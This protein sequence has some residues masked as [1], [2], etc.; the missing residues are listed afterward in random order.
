M[1]CCSNCFNNS[2]LQK[3]ISESSKSTGQCDF[4]GA[5]GI[6]VIEVREL[7]GLFDN[8]LSMYEV[9]EDYESGEPLID[10]IQWHWQIF[11]EENLGEDNMARLLEKIANSDWDDDD[12]E[13]MLRARELYVPPAGRPL[14]STHRERWEEFCSDV[15]ENPDVPLPFDEYFSG[16][17]AEFEEH[18]PFG[19]TLYRSVRGFAVGQYGER[20][21]F[22]VGAPPE[23][24]ALAGRGNVEDDR[25][26]Y[27]A[28]QEKTAIAEVRPPLGYRVSIGTLRLVREARILDLTKDVDDLNPFTTESLGW[29][30][31][32]R[33][34]LGGF[35]EEMSRPLERDDDKTHYVPCQRLAQ[36]IREE[37][38]DGI[39][40]SSALC[41]GGSNVMLFDPS[42]AD[43]LECRLVRISQLE[44]KYEDEEI[45]PVGDVLR[46]AST[47]SV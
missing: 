30:V 27:C 17:F 19:A 2:W 47:D 43:V 41:P 25:V 36:Y 11:S 37:G 6:P 20:I 24:R 32:I 45:Q 31:E 14:H 21:P 28:D 8:L 39:R 18:L 33:S 16:D 46:T 44:L 15:R 5:E 12:G 34:L 22:R 13:P 1:V 23:G 29:F 35:D 3:Y 42:I 9:A 40:Y 10:L 7:G 26:L 38:F 4:C